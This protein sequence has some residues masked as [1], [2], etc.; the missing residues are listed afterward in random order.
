MIDSSTI[1]IMRTAFQW[2]YQRVLI[3]SREQTIGEKN[4]LYITLYQLDNIIQEILRYA[5][6]DD[7]NDSL[8]VE[9]LF[10]SV[11][12]QIKHKNK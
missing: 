6:K 12:E 9:E 8:V 5:E 3:D 2:L 1:K 10:K 7:S 4:D 11:K